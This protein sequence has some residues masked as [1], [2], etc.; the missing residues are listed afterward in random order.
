MLIRSAS[1]PISSISKSED[2][3][4]F[5]KW[6]GE[7]RLEEYEKEEDEVLNNPKKYS[8]TNNDEE[9]ISSGDE[10][11]LDIQW[12]EDE[13]STT[14]NTRTSPGHS[15]SSK[16]ALGGIP[17]K[18]I[19]LNLRKIK[20]FD[21]ITTADRTEARQYLKG[22]IASMKQRSMFAVTRHIDDR[23]GRENKKH[24]ADSTKG[25]GNHK[26]DSTSV[27]NDCKFGKLPSKMTPKLAAALVLESLALNRVES[28]EGMARCYDAIVTTGTAL[29]E[30]QGDYSSERDTGN[31]STKN[32]GD[33]KSEKRK[34]SRAELKIDL[35]LLLKVTLEQTSGEVIL[36]LARLR[37]LCV[38]KRYQRRFVQRVAPYLV[39][40]PG[41]SMWCLRH[42]E[43]MKAIFCATE[44]ILDAAFDILESKFYL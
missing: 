18:Y 41:A 32:N 11:G 39:R 17:D 6:V 4:S 26:Q 5:E 34:P 37:K 38:T 1:V 16:A 42:V 25:H 31:E 40:P 8:A 7:A 33:D 27:L 9:G 44:M 21:S 35:S 15:P 24:L 36:G 43:D 13:S 12:E 2:S 19:P 20:W 29:L 30:A 14:A 23:H 10:D 22:E 3:L 28:L